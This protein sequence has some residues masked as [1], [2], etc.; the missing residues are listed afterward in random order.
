MK[1]FLPIFVVNRS[2]HFKQLE[3]ID[4]DFGILTTS[5][6][7]D[8]LL[9][10]FRKIDKPY[11][12]DNGVFD[13]PS[14]ILP[15]SANVK[16]PW[17]LKIKCWFQNNHWQRSLI[18][19]PESQLREYLSNFF[20][21]CNTFS[22]DYVINP[23]V[24]GEPLLS[25]YLA[26][27]GIEEYTKK[28]RTFTLIGV[29]QAGYSLY[30]PYKRNVKTSFQHY[31]SPKSF[32]ASLISEYRN[33]GYKKIALGG[34]LKA[35]TYTPMGLKFGLSNQELDELLSWSRPDLVL[36]GLALTRLPILKK[37]DVWADSSNWI[38]WKEEYD[39][40]RFANRDVMSEVF[41]TS[42]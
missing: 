29:V 8:N 25:L 35:N 6:E 38:W 36:G 1:K 40:R 34:L 22:P 12:I 14:S 42:L 18:V 9:H 24:I 15:Y 2:A 3:V 4:D 5:L 11:F 10:S 26:Q 7:S 28:P 17:Y 33:I 39:P 23:D 32:L 37:H 30:Y 31:D 20:D 19:A 27:L 41:D 13:N 16:L 21:R